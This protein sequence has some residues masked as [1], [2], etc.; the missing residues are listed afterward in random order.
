VAGR[1]GDRH[2]GEGGDPKAGCAG[3]SNGGNEKNTWVQSD[4]LNDSE[5][6]NERG[7]GLLKRDAR[8]TAIDTTWGAFLSDDEL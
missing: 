7:P 1:V 4:G 6:R 3:V 8:S 2:V 5:N